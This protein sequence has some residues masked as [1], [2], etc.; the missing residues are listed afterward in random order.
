MWSP[1][2]RLLL[3][4][5]GCPHLLTAVWGAA[6][7]LPCPLTLSAQHL[8]LCWCVCLY[9]KAPFPVALYFSH[10]LIIRPYLNKPINPFSLG[11]PVSSSVC[12]QMIH[13]PNHHLKKDKAPSEGGQAGGGHYKCCR[14]SSVSHTGLLGGR[15]G[16]YLST[17]PTHGFSTRSLGRQQHFNVR[18]KH[19]ACVTIATTEWQR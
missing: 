16:V 13:T 15:T 14:K 7:L 10:P 9:P 18:W 2:C 3:G 12:K 6:F 11:T 8:S 17:F 19:R 5:S 4:P 1:C